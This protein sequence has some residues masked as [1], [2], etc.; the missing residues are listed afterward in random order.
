MGRLREKRRGLLTSQ[1]DCTKLTDGPREFHGCSYL[2]PPMAVFNTAQVSYLLRTRII[3]SNLH[4]RNGI[5]VMAYSHTVHL[6]IPEGYTCMWHTKTCLV[7]MV[8]TLTNIV[9]CTC[10]WSIPFIKLLLCMF[11]QATD[12][13]YCMTLC[14]VATYPLYKYSF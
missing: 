10:I 12:L 1:D 13:L 14:V 9:T 6:H 3:L 8:H 2:T 4:H 5:I 7:M 11:V